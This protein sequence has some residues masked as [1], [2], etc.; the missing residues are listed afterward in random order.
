M[1]FRNLIYCL[2][3]LCLLAL[4]SCGPDNG[5]YAN[6]ALGDYNVKITPSLSFKFDGNSLPPTT[7]EVIETTG[8][9]TKNDEEGN[10]TIKINGV[11]GYI[12]DI[13]IHAYCSGLGMK[14]DDSSYN[15]TLNNGEYGMI[16]CDMKLDNP[17]ASISNAKIFNWNSSVS[18]QCDVNYIGLDMKCDVSGSINFNLTPIITK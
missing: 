6:K 4:S 14:M 10:V 8:S 16:S 7:F 18:G 1:K 12:S 13:E 11:N 15:G 9:I 3:V 2:L 5:D 17:T